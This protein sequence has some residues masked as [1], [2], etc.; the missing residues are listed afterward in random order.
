MSMLQLHG[1]PVL[2]VDDDPH[3]RHLIADLLRDEGY[4]VITADDGSEALRFVAIDC[5]AVIVLDMRMPVVDGWQFV[6]AYRAMPGPHAPIVVV[7]AEHD[8]RLCGS[9]IGA[10]AVVPKPFEI[11]SLVDAVARVYRPVEGDRHS[12]DDS[13]A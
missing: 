12:R 11:E 3:I 2:V 13:A 6:R 4:P 9:E 8:A 5:P 10:A 1:R 7:T